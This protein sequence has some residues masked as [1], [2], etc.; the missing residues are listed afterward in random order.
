[1][2]PFNKPARTGHEDS[3]VVD[4]MNGTAMSGNNIYTR[5]CER[6]FEQSLP[7]KRAML[8]TS[9]THA[10]E[11]AAILLDIQ[12]GDEVIVPSYTFVSSANAFALRGAKIVFAEVVPAT[13]NLDIDKLE[14]LITVNT[15]AI[16]PVHYAGVSCDMLGLMDLAKQYNVK[17]VEDAAQCIG[18]KYNNQSVG[19]HGHLATF[20]FHE[21]KNITAAGEGGMLVI[22]D[23]ELKERAEILRDKGTN[24]RQFYE[25]KVDKYT[26]VDIGSSYLLGELNAA[27]LYSQLEN[28]QQINA[29]RLTCWNTYYQQLAHLESRGYLQRPTIPA[30]CEHNGHIFHIRVKD[31]ECRTNLIDYLYERNVVTVFHYVPLHSSPMGKKVGHCLTNMQVTTKESERLLRLPLYFGLK[32]AEIELVTQ[33]IHEYFE[34]QD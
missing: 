26:W 29:A 3:F 18:S 20:S 23:E 13:L 14:K 19:I 6:W 30:D 27:Y 15:K 7:C 5:L 16:V 8:V 2:I 12:A 11:M 9:C 32:N 28:L 22:N 1:M 21:T 17:V 24:R 25:G 34:T 10:L 31:L 33:H 4:A